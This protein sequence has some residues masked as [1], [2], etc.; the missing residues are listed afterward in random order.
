MRVFGYIIGAFLLV[1]CYFVADAFIE[2]FVLPFM[3]GGKN[4]GLALLIGVIQL[5]IWCVLFLISRHLVQS[6]VRKR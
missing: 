4:I 5:V 6:I 2:Y 3:P 1:L